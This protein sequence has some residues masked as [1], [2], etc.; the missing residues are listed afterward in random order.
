MAKQLT[1]ADVTEEFLLEKLKNKNVIWVRDD[2]LSMRGMA[3]CGDKELYDLLEHT[4]NLKEKLRS[5]GHV[6]EDWSDLN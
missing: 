4:A 6:F 1:I 2:Y 3:F 5:E